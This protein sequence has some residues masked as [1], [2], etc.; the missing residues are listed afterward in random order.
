MPKNIPYYPD[1]EHL[2]GVAQNLYHG[3]S[4]EQVNG[5]VDLLLNFDAY[6]R[7]NTSVTPLVQEAAAAAAQQAAA[8]GGAQPGAEAQ[9][10]D[11]AE[12]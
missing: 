10:P 4:I 1:Q 11:N 7:Q 5:V 6:A 9:T 2:G 3:T 12:Q 8:A